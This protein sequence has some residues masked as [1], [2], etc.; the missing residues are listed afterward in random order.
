MVPRRRS[1]PAGT[2]LTALGIVLG[3]LAALC[4]GASDF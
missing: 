1:A 3:L 4:Y 2:G